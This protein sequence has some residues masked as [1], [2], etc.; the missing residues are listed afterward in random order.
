MQ[1]EILCSPGQRSLYF[2]AKAAHGVLPYAFGLR[3]EVDQVAGVDGNGANIQR[4]ALLAHL[5]RLFRFYRRGLPLSRTR[6]EELKGIATR[7]GRTLHRCPAAAA[8]AYMNTDS[9]LCHRR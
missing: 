8:G 1:H 5:L 4:R 7:F 3:A 2:A 6:T 9:L